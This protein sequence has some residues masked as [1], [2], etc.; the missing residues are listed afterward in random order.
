[1]TRIRA[2]RYVD[3]PFSAALE[4]AEQAASRRTGLF[5]TFSP[6]IGERVHFVAASTNDETD[7]A[8]KH[9][10]LLIAWRPKRRRLFP[11]FRGV[12]TVRPNGRG[13]S[14]R[15]AGEY[16]P[17]FGRLGDAFDT[18]AGRAIAKR[19]MDHFLHDL[20]DDIERAYKVERTHAR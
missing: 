15:L 13:V 20:A 17:P 1:M 16:E 19:T 10:A 18:I 8:R 3:C 12:L 6:P 9:D 14:L 11:D 5:L 2:H 4:L 7:T